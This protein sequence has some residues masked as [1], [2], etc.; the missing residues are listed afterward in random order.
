MIKMDQNF[1]RVITFAFFGLS[2]IALVNRILEWDFEDIILIG[3]MMGIVIG[4]V[5]GFVL[6]W[7]LACYLVPDKPKNK[8][9]LR[10]EK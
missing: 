1:K 4:T 8:N 9:I 2:A 5:I 3:K 7:L 6:L 10:R